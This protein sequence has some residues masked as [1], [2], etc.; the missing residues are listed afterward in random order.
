MVA[1]VPV[2]VMVV[3]PRVPVRVVDAA[4]GVMALQTEAATADVEN[5]APASSMGAAMA[6]DKDKRRSRWRTEL[7]RIGIPIEAGQKEVL[8]QTTWFTGAGR[9]YVTLVGV[10]VTICA[11]Q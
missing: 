2:R 5:A 1:A 3:S 6:T 8:R 4:P 10:M 9:S 11:A 7:W